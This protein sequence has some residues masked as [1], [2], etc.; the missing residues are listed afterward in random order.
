MAGEEI[1][2]QLAIIHLGFSL[3]WFRRGVAETVYLLECLTKVGVRQLSQK[4]SHSWE[5]PPGF[6]RSG[7]AGLAGLRVGSRN[8][9][10][11]VGR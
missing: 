5:S 6:P 10:K 11:M 1:F 3:L 8:P 4:H 7:F 2:S 9:G